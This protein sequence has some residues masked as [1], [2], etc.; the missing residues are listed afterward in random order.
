MSLYEFRT[1]VQAILFLDPDDKGF[2]CRYTPTL[3][4]ITQSRLFKY[5]PEIE[6]IVRHDLSGRA[7]LAGPGENGILC[8]G[9]FTLHMNF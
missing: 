3:Q 9:L 6:E 4:E 7:I 2:I 5:D 8:V 1:T